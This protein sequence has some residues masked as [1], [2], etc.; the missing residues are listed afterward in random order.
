[1]TWIDISGEIV[2]Q[3]SCTSSEVLEAACSP[4]IYRTSPCE[5]SGRT[6]CVLPTATGS[7]YGGLVWCHITCSCLYQPGHAHTLISSR[8]IE[9]G[10]RREEGG[11]L[12]ISQHHH[13][14]SHQQTSKHQSWT[15]PPSH[16]HY[17]QQKV[18][19]AF[20]KVRLPGGFFPQLEEN[21]SIQ[22]CYPCH[23]RIWF[24]CLKSGSLARH[25]IVTIVLSCHTIH[26]PP[27]K[28]TKL[29][30]IYF[31]VGLC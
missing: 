22:K 26:S 27:N 13:I 9:G 7:L 29:I 24:Q 1:M 14:T 5:W 6:E 8:G 10:G 28:C 12:T 31:C 23:V 30:A 4:L 15:A 17:N 11:C 25:T 16:I 3:W 18:A 2:W 21:V 20:F 19:V